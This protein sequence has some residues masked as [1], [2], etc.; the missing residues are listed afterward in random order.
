MKEHAD[1]NGKRIFGRPT[2][3]RRKKKVTGGVT[4]RDYSFRMIPTR[5]RKNSN[6][7]VTGGLEK[8]RLAFHLEK[9]L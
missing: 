9:T 8:R 3:P 2:V 6:R 4:Q 5:K 7:K 1:Q